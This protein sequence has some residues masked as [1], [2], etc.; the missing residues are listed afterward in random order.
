[1]STRDRHLRLLS[2]AGIR[3]SDATTSLDTLYERIPANSDPNGYLDAVGT[4]VEDL[5]PD[6]RA[7]ILVDIF[8]A[9]AVR[10]VTAI[11]AF[12][13]LEPVEFAEDV[14]LCDK[15]RHVLSTVRPVD[16]TVWRA[17]MERARG[18]DI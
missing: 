13:E 11:L 3:G 9:D 7:R 17:G 4:V 5:T 8:G 16:P 10:A 15:G 2:L 6:K 18:G 12:G 1:M 14:R